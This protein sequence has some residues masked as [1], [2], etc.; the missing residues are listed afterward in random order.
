MHRSGTS[1]LTGSFCELGFNAGEHLLPAVANDNP[2]GYFEDRRI[3]EIHDRLLGSFGLDWRSLN[4][5]P[6]SWRI[7][8]ETLR[9]RDELGGIVKELMRPGL[10]F[11]IKD[12]RI[13]RLMPLW[14][15]VLSEAKVAAKYVLVARDPA[16]VAASLMRREKMSAHRAGQLW[17]T[18]QL[19]AEYGARGKDRVFLTYDALL[20]DWRAELS[21]CYET[22]GMTGFQA[23][24]DVAERIDDFLSQDLRNHKIRGSAALDPLALEVFSGFKALAS[25]SANF[26]ALQENFDD[27]RARSNK[28]RRKDIALSEAIDRSLSGSSYFQDLIR[29]AVASVASNDEEK[30]ERLNQINAQGDV[31]IS[32]HEEQIRAISGVRNKLESFDR[33]DGQHAE[34][35][36]SFEEQSKKISDIHSKLEAFDRIDV[37]NEGLKESL[38]EQLRA[39]S[40]IRGGLEEFDRSHRDALVGSLAGLSREISE[41]TQSIDMLSNVEALRHESM[42]LLSDRIDVLSAI[43]NELIQ[44]KSAVNE[45]KGDLADEIG[46]IRDAVQETSHEQHL[47]RVWAERRTFTYWWRRLTQNKQG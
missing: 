13:C 18:Y 27:W 11:V 21:R 5:L 39:I 34:V 28:K 40:G 2:R 44:L 6:E 26:D 36:G 32:A 43:T 20:K 12:P 35:V 23:N 42:L 19:E 47:V 24:G 38:A 41:V 4:F 22:L 9:A 46:R 45:I 1:A 14:D 25:N 3:V 15:E 33:I 30:L 16:E 8:K 37:Q 10:S 31:L 7:N 17:L 29:D